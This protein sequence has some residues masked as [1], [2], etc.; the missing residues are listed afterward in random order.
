MG[1]WAWAEK[2]KAFKWLAKK[3]QGLALFLHLHYCRQRYHIGQLEDKFKKT[4]L[5]RFLKIHGFEKG[6][7]AWIDKDEVLRMRKRIG[8]FFQYH[9]RLFRD[10]EIKGHYE[11]APEAR[12]W[13][14]FWEYF[15][16]PR[17]RYFRKLLK[18][19]LGKKKRKRRD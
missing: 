5:Y 7:L 8:R 19:L 11:Y 16:H 4:D 3:F 15:F 12:P 2:Y 17:K 18:G 9:I 1:F 13:K 14:H 6:T 10:G